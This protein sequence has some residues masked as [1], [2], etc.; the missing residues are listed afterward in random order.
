M[1]KAGLCSGTNTVR[2]LLLF[3]IEI[4]LQR[5]STRHQLTHPSDGQFITF[6]WSEG[7][8]EDEKNTEV[9]SSDQEIVLPLILGKKTLNR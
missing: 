6:D 1:G 2:H 4:R 9:E 3:A 7:N 5:F 8:K